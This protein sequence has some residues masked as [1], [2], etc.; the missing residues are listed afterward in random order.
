[1]IHCMIFVKFEPKRTLP[2]RTKPNRAEPNRIVTNRREQN[3]TEPETNHNKIE[4]NKIKLKRIA[5][6]ITAPQIFKCWLA[7]YIIKCLDCNVENPVNNK[8]IIMNNK[9]ISKY[10]SNS[11]NIEQGNIFSK[12]DTF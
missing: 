11:T 1:M 5:N 3:K 4:R 2:N 8:N 10:M 7:L 9:P 6:K 12:T